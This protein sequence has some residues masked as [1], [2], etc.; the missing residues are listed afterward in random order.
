MFLRTIVGMLTCVALLTLS[1]GC[2]PRADLVGTGRIE[3]ETQDARLVTINKPSVHA[4]DKGIVVSGYIRRR[5]LSRA[6]TWSGKVR[7]E[8]LD[9]EGKT[10]KSVVTT[11]YPRNLGRRGRGLKGSARYSARLGGL[12]DKA[13]KVRVQY[14]EN[15]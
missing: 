2:K 1:L 7:V 12:P 6:G 10:L 4:D 5:Y 3:V 9:A 13:V 14:V 8:V 15:G 11:H